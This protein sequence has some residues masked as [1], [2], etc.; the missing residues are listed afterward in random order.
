MTINTFHGDPRPSFAYEMAK[1]LMSHC[2]VTYINFGLLHVD[3]N[4]P[5]YYVS[6]DIFYERVANR[7]LTFNSS[8]TS[9][10]ERISITAILNDTMPLIHQEF[11]LS[12]SLDEPDPRVVL[13]PETATV[14]IF[15]VHGE[16]ELLLTFDACI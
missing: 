7:S 2:Y 12:L 8:H 11:V 15:E 1:K 16:G 10:R 6:V 9:F 4:S 13:E 3:N 5:L 14:K